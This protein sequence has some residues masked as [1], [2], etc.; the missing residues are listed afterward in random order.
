PEHL[1]NPT[2]YPVNGTGPEDVLVDTHGR[3]LTGVDDG[4]V[5]ALSDHGRRIDTL[6]DTGGRPLGLEQLPDG[7]I[8]VC[9]AHRGLL[10]ITPDTGRVHTLLPATGP[11]RPALCNNAAVTADGTV[12]LSD[13]SRRFPL[14]QWRNDLLEHSGTGR[15]WRISPDGDAE[16]LLNGLHFANGVALAADESFVA[17]AETGAY[18]LTRLWL[19]GPRAGE[20][21][22][23]LPALGGFPDNIAT[24]TDG[25]IWV[26]QAAARNPLLD[27]AHAH[28]PAALHLDR[29]LPESLRVQPRPT[30]WLLAVDDTG[31]VVRELQAHSRGFGMVTGVREH[32]GTL[33][34]GSLTSTAVATLHPPRPPTDTEHPG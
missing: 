9:D 6:A 34:L 28:L 2:L 24:G 14:E 4:R 20:T 27:L 13:S 33:Y 15:L 1:G 5:L 3:V 12:Y 29:A 26:T 22:T 19:R 25:L 11:H 18:R 7:E 16:P 8:L 21:D 30:V 32:H 31:R 17:V 10:R 23:L